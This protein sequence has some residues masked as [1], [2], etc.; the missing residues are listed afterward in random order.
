VNADWEFFQQYMDINL[1]LPNTPGLEPYR[2]L[3]PTTAEY[4]RQH[5][6]PPH[7][8]RDFDISDLKP[9][10][11]KGFEIIEKFPWENLPTDHI[12]RELMDKVPRIAR[13]PS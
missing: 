9:E 4:D 10:R 5:N 1:P 6:R 12:P 3:D 2:H 13:W 8:W 11:D 7:Y